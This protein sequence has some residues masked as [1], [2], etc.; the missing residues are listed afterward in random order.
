MKS[1][2]AKIVLLYVVDSLIYLIHTIDFYAD[3]LSKQGLL[4]KLDTSNYP[5]E[6]PCYR[7]ERKK[8]PGTFTDETNGKT[9][10]EQVAL[11]AKAYGYSLV[12]EEHI[13]A[14]GVSKAVVKNQ[15]TLNDYKNCL[16]EGLDQTQNLDGY[17]PHR[18]MTSFR[19]Y[20][21]EVKTIS[22][23]KLA[24]NRF[25][26]K[27]YILNNRIDTLPWGHHRIK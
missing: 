22:T 17:S 11:R 14:K 26:D 6:H 10:W 19:S 5:P 25:D 21:H 4:E 18:V 24:L 16:F 27:R 9:I 2:L 20:K 7:T 1:T 15:L 23:N 13:K 8:V 12:G 3:V